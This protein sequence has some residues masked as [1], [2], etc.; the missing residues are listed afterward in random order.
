MWLSLVLPRKAVIA[1]TQLSNNVLSR[2]LRLYDF[3]L[4]FARRQYACMYLGPTL[5]A[6]DMVSATRGK[7]EMASNTPMAAYTNLGFAEQ[8]LHRHIT[9]RRWQI[10]IR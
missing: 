10:V 4:K 8:P 1:A 3:T 7:T 6:I 9:P 2:N 5:G